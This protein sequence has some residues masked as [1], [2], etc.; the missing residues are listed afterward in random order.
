[1]KYKFT[2]KDQYKKL[3]ELYPEIESRVTEAVEADGCYNT[4]GDY[5]SIHNVVTGC[6]DRLWVSENFFE[7]EDTR[8]YFVKA[9][10]PLSK[11]LNG[12]VLDDKQYKELQQTIKNQMEDGTSFVNIYL[13][14]FGHK[15][16]FNIDKEDIGEE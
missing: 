16:Y 3:K 5:L 6:Y 10:N 12:D 2:L 8:T 7:K 4:F 1:M 13:T 11:V 15:Q 9:T 14:M